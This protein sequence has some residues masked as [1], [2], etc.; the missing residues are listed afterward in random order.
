MFHQNVSLSKMKMKMKMRNKTPDS[1]PRPALYTHFLSLFVLRQ[2]NGGGRN[3]LLAIECQVKLRMRPRSLQVLY[4]GSHIGCYCPA[5][6]LNRIM[7]R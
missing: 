6:L 3:D 1:R 4:N 2:K 5:D 7:V